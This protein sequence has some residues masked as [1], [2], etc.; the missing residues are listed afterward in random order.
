M[1]PQRRVLLPV[2][3]Y[4]LFNPSL[5][6]RLLPQPEIA[7]FRNRMQLPFAVQISNLYHSCP[8][9][10]FGSSLTLITPPPGTFLF[11]QGLNLRSFLK[12]MSRNNTTACA[13]MPSPRPVKPSPS[14]VV[15]LT[16]TSF[17][18]KPRSTARFFFISA[19]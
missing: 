1:F 6:R 11:F 19:R 5:R 18:F 4:F 2:G 16:P 9:C 10:R 7:E 8:S 14:V 12:N 15:A 17:S 13:A 3:G